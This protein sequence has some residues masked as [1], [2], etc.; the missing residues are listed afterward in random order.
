[1]SDHAGKSSIDAQDAKL[2][3]SLVAEDSFI[4]PPPREVSLSPSFFLL[5]ILLLLLFVIPVI[6]FLCCSC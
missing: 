4:G 1:M 2:A 5:P 3:I 6:L